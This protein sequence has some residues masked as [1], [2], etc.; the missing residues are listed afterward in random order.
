MGR[1][2]GELFCTPA[3]GVLCWH[4]E[5]RTARRA[6]AM[7]QS[8]NPRSPQGP[9]RG[10]SDAGGFNWR[11][12]VLFSIALVILVLAFVTDGKGSGPRDVTYAD[13]R[14]A[15]DQGRVVLNDPQRPLKVVTGDNA[16]DGVISGWYH[17]PAAKPAAAEGERVAF[18]VPVNFLMQA[19][20]LREILGE[21]VPFRR[22]EAAGLPQPGDGEV[23]TLKD[24][25]R[26]MARGEVVRDPQ[27]ALEVLAP[28]GSFDGVLVGVREKRPAAAA[29]E[30]VR[31]E[32]SVPMMAMEREVNQLL[33]AH[34]VYKREPDYL[35]T[36]LFTFLPV[37]LLIL[38]LFFLFRQQM[39]A[40][41]RGAMS[42]GKSKARLLT[43][44]RNKVTFKDVAGIQEAKEELWEIV[45][46]LRDPRKFQKLGGSIP[47]GVLMVGA[48]GTG[49]T[50]LARAIAG[51]ADVPFFSISGSDFVEM[52]VGV[53]ASRVRDMFEQ[54]K[55]HAPC[56]IFVDEIDAVGR[57]RGHGLGGGHDE[58]EQTLNQ[59]LVE[60]DGFDTQ[61]GVI[62]IAATNRPDVLDPAL[63]RPG[64]FD[65]Q[66]K[67]AADVDLGVIARGTPGFSGA[68]LASLINEAA[69][70][71]ARRGL[72]AV[73]LPELE[74]A[75]DKVRWGRERR[76]LALSEEEKKVTA[77][78][79]AGHALLLATLQ[80]TD[81]LHKV[82]IIPRGPYLGAA[83]HLPV[84][85]KYH[86]YKQQ[87]KEELIVT[88]GGRVAEEIIF[89]DVTSGAS[90]DIRMA[91]T[92]ARRMVCEWGMSEALGMVE[93]G[94][95]HGEVFLARDISRDRNY[96]EATALKIDLEI[97]RL[98]DWAYNE[99]RNIVLGKRDK[100][101]LIAQALLE[102][103]TLDRSHI[104]DLIEHGEMRNPPDLRRPPEIPG[105]TR[106]KK[107]SKSAGEEPKGGDG[108]IPGEV[109][110]APA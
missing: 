62:I 71:A 41:G 77:Y 73:T 82:T 31:F 94:E 56:L 95:H 74:E 84:E 16:Y 108:T 78:H 90:A 98:I 29:A 35:R 20:T 55:K 27:T 109:V 79:E 25:R 5:R 19:E 83:F 9:P 33:G 48:P 107:G 26:I 102:Y 12:L 1:G 89:G 92:L 6:I 106:S 37:L 11:L 40:A 61:E 23:L 57:H 21:D 105:K 60:M 87:G 58:R 14:A 70:L 46:F 59:L 32:V 103:E 22:V 54:G 68:E 43:M 86:F 2:A 50:L 93:Y 44:D 30:P 88:M 72:P 65:R 110:G 80:R 28:A 75:R 53:G 47:K 36:A 99:A 45:E 81:P 76:S 97:K 10:G 3:A 66:V 52:F 15:W 17:P 8:P 64:R 34:A 101:E 100:L 24:F 38:L 85:D 18:Q 91:T 4:A 63:L 7:S 51:E 49:K 42:F 67:L 39:K 96:S 69:L 104:M 13:F